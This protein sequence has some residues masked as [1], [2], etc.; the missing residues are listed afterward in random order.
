MLSSNRLSY[1]LFES[2]WTDQP[3]ST[4]MCI[5]IFGEYL[6]QPHEL[7]IGKLYP[8]TL[9]TFTMVCLNFGRFVQFFFI[10]NIWFQ[11][12]NSAYSMFNVLKKFAA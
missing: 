12:L 1:S 2:D 3:Q 10:E 4:K 7:I 9:E 6:R 5:L 11:I 8:L